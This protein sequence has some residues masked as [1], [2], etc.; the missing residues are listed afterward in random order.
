MISTLEKVKDR[1]DGLIYASTRK[2]S[3]RWAE[4]LL[5]NGIKA[6]AYHAGLSADKR[7]SIQQQ[8]ISGK[9]PWI[10]ATNAFGMGI[11]KPDCRYVFHEI[12][13][14]SLEPIIRRLEELEGTGK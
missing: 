6:E 14:N 9:L 11:D 10:A 3:E 4:R 7:T 13:P 1:G 2:N 12:T 5:R 8:W